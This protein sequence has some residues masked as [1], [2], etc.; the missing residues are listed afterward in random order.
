[1]AVIWYRRDDP[2]M[3][4]EMFFSGRVYACYFFSSCNVLFFGSLNVRN[5]FFGSGCVH[6]FCF[7]TSML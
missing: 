7:G 3:Y 1:M 5:F 6:E 4:K 2:F